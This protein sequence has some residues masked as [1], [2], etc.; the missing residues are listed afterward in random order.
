MPTRTS[1]TIPLSVAAIWA[2]TG[3]VAACSVTGPES[4]L[5]AVAQTATAV[6]ELDVERA[7]CRS[8]MLHIEKQ[9]AESGAPEFQ[10]ARPQILGR[11]RGEP[12]IWLR[13]PRATP[14]H[15]LP[16]DAR[17]LLKALEPA[18][19][20]TWT[21]RLRARYRHDPDLL[22]KLVL[23]EGYVYSSDPQMAL[24]L[25]NGFSLTDLFDE[26]E[27]WLQ[28]GARTLRLQ[29]SDGRRPEYRHAEGE[30]AGERAHLLF[31]D[32]VARTR[33]GLSEPLHRDL[34]HL[35]E[36]E[37]VDRVDVE[38]LGSSALVARLRL[39]DRWLSAVLRSNGPELELE[40]VDADRD[41]RDA[42]S[43]WQEED[44]VRRN[45]LAEL[46]KSI[47]A[48]VT[49]KPRFDRPRDAE[50][51]LNDGELRP[52]WNWAYKTGRS[53]FTLD[54]KSYAVFDS[55]G[56]PTPP[57][58]CMAFVLDAF[59][60][61]SGNWYET[62]DNPRGRTR[63]TL[64]FDEHDI[65]N[66][67]GVLAFAEYAESKP[68]LFEVR[69]FSR[70][71]RIEFGRRTEFFAFLTENADE[72]RPGDIVAIRGVKSDGVVHQHSLLIETADPVTGFPHG[73]ADQMRHPRRRTWEA[74]MAEAP[75]R[76]IYYRVRP[77]PALLERLARRDQR[78]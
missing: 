53:G 55:R 48:F 23:R 22:R 50:D 41:H 27:I 37:G 15:T 46:R 25:V 60:R 44:R 38:H 75:R 61:A 51:H 54:E 24:A 32:R 40:C 14:P 66:R 74:M 68:D 39:K 58:V 16:P 29:R 72:I 73:L 6:S 19:P 69:R 64:D 71:E 57:Q 10:R 8:R 1:W 2:A 20:V 11:A 9:P 70:E 34:R 3:A 36:R 43:T 7:A 13:E 67:S 49:E 56:R 17:T 52:L 59:E 78:P 76:S 77:K 45:A 30:L 33:Q 12:V 47:T 31:A 5:R 28:R 42:L 35:M 21:R 63:G 18:R 26:P 65:Q 4:P 62:I